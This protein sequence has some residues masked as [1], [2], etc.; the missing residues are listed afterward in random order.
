M[1][2][3][4]LVGWIINRIRKQA[5]KLILIRYSTINNRRWFKCVIRSSQT[6]SWD[7]KLT[8]RIF[9]FTEQD[10][11]VC[12]HTLQHIL[13]SDE[14]RFALRFIDGRYRVYRRRG[15]HFTNHCM[16]E[17]DRFGCGSV[18]VWTG[19]CHDGRSQL[20]IVQ[21]TLNVV[22][23]GDIFLVISFCPVC[24]SENLIT[25]FNM[26]MQDVTWFVFVK[27]F[28]TIQVFGA[29]YLLHREIKSTKIV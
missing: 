17:S 26:T 1:N 10:A 28:W 12:F 5:T 20:K 24:N 7:G 3:Y 29:Q 6:R 15:E 16:Y 21:G 14:S 23:Y 19:I 22:K 27:I 25:S 13:Y 4:K 18:M 11:I 2:M 9:S 8:F